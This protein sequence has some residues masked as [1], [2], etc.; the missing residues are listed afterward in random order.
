MRN[1]GPIVSPSLS[2]PGLSGPSMSLSSKAS[3]GWPAFAGQ[4]KFWFGDN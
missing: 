3:P 4:D 1:L 2:W